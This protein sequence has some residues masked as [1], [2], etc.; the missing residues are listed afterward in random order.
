MTHRPCGTIGLSYETYP[1]IY[2][3]SSKLCQLDNVALGGNHLT[4]NPQVQMPSRAGCLWDK[5]ITIQEIAIPPH[6]I[7]LVSDTR[8]R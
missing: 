3:Y 7:Q 4:G 8:E 1:S 5:H 2:F 6:P